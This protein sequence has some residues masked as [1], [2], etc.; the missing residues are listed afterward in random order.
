MQIFPTSKVLGAVTPSDLMF[1][2]RGGIVY[3]MLMTT[4]KPDFFIPR[5]ILYD[6]IMGI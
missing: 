2:K 3:F 4:A 5:E 6:L 1:L